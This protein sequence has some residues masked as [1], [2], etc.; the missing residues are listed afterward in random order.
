MTLAKRCQVIL[1]GAEQ[2]VTQLQE[3]FSNGVGALREEA[4]EYGSEPEF[5]DEPVYDE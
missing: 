3:Q 1:Q 2:R 5:E 4:A